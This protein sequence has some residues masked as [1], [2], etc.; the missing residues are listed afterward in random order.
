MSGVCRTSRT[1]TTSDALC[2][3]A[4]L[5][6]VT[7]RARLGA[8]DSPRPLKGAS[9]ELPAPRVCVPLISIADQGAP[10][11]EQPEPYRSVTGQRYAVTTA[12]GVCQSV[13]FAWLVPSRTVHIGL[14]RSGVVASTPPLQS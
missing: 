14:E 10:G 7:C 11:S 3:S 6:S 12:T 9:M 1:V 2:A 5:L 13:G 4:T 8:G